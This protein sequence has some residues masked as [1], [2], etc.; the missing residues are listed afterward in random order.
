MKK[1]SYSIIFSITIGAATLGTAIQSQA[2]NT[3]QRVIEHIAGDVY[4]ASDNNHNT[5]F[6]VTTDG[7]IL[8]DPINTA[9]SEWLKSEL[10]S[11]FGVPVRYVVYSHN[12]WDHASGGAVFADTALFVGHEN[13][14]DYLA[15]PSDSTRLTDVIGQYAPVAAL[16]SNG[17][18]YVA[19]G[20]V[21]EAIPA[22]QFSAFDENGDDMLSDAEVARGPL[23]F[24][25]APTITYTD[26]IDIRLGGKQASATWVGEMN[27][28]F[29]MS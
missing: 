15:M 25:H 23:R 13:M 20:E 1:L 28:S 4:R 6:M 21:G 2:Q 27:H 24:V 12:H 9:F 26:N 17:D 5:A 29:D 7:I 18:G 10:Q 11:R 19:R 14:L 22:L 3:P 8:A 16:D